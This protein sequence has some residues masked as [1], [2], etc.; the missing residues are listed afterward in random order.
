MSDENKMLA[1]EIL[2]DIQSVYELDKHAPRY[3]VSLS[4]PELITELGADW[5]KRTE[6]TTGLFNLLVK[7]GVVTG[8][9]LLD[10]E[11]LK[12]NGGLD[13]ELSLDKRKF[14]QLLAGL[15]QKSSQIDDTNL[16]EEFVLDLSN[17]KLAYDGN[18]YEFKANRLTISWLIIE[19]L[20]DT[21]PEPYLL[22]DTELSI[23]DITVTP[24]ALN[25]CVHKL[26]KMLKNLTGSNMNLISNNQYVLRFVPNL[27]LKKV[28]NNPL[29]FDS[30]V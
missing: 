13:T 18:I 30:Q 23:A 28:G 10:D 24:Q 14:E 7:E 25:S 26:N 8:S 29:D 20:F 17:K 22:D 4:K 15:G 3:K 6:R 27:K 21:F 9:R 11:S 1:L 5:T 2:S 19:G 16:F 12:E